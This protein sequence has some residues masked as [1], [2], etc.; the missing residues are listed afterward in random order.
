MTI[1]KVIVIPNR[2]SI[3]LFKTDFD[4]DSGGGGGVEKHRVWIVV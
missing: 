2:F 1:V 4:E 3:S